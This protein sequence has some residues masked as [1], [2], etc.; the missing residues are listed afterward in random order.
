MFRLIEGI[1]IVRIPHTNN[2]NELRNSGKT[3]ESVSE[4]A[5]CWSR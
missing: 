4:T 5:N 1:K 3:L 2:Y